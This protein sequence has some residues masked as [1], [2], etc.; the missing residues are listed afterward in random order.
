MTIVTYFTIVLIILTGIG[1]SQL[2]SIKFSET[3][4]IEQ[5]KTVYG[6]PYHKSSTSYASAKQLAPDVGILGVTPYEGATLPL[7][8]VTIDVLVYNW[9]DTDTASF[10]VNCTVQ[11]KTSWAYEPVTGNTTVTLN[12]TEYENVSFNWLPSN[13]GIYSINL[14]TNLSGDPNPNNN[15][16]TF[17]VTIANITDVELWIQFPLPGTYDLSPK[18]VTAELINVGNVN[19]TTD[20]NVHLEIINA[21]SYSIDHVDDQVQVASTISIPGNSTTIS[22]TSWTPSAPGTYWIN[23]TA[24]LPSDQNPNNDYDNITVTIVAAPAIHDVGVT[25][26][27]D[28]GSVCTE[29]VYLVNATITN[30]GTEL[31]GNIP[32]YCTIFNLNTGLTVYEQQAY[33]LNLAPGSSDTL[34]FPA[35]WNAVPGDYVINATTMLPTDV[36]N[37][38][39]FSVA[40]ITIIPG[41]VM[42][43]VHVIAPP[44]LYGKP[45]TTVVYE[46]RIV[47][48]GP[49][50]DSFNWTARSGHN[51]IKSPN[52]PDGTMTGTTGVLVP[53]EEEAVVIE[54][55]VPSDAGA[56]VTDRLNLTATSVA[57]PAVS[58]SNYT[59]TSTDEIYEVVVEVP[60]GQIQNGNPGD[61]LVYEF[62]VINEG[63][64]GDK[65][66]LSAIATYAERGWIATITSSNPTPYVEPGSSTLVTVML[67]IPELNRDTMI[68]DHTYAGATEQLTLRAECTNGYT[69]SAT[70]TTTVN[71]IYKAELRATPESIEVNYAGVTRE[72]RFTITVRN[73]CN[74]KDEVGGQ[75][76]IDLTNSTP[77]FIRGGLGDA[78]DVEASRY[79]ASLSDA[80]LTLP[81]GAAD[82]V[83]LT[84]TVP[85]KPLNGSCMVAVTG[86]PRGLSGDPTADR[87]PGTVAVYVY[88]R[89]I[90]GVEVKEPIPAIQR[91]APLQTLTYRFTIKNTGNGLDNFNLKSESEHDW[92]TAIVETTPIG[93]LW[94]DEEF[95]VRV[96]VTI[97]AG[98]SIG[99]TDILY[100][101]AWS[102]FNTSV[103]SKNFATT[104]VI[105]GYAVDLEPEENAS[106][107]KPRGSVNYTINVTNAGNGWDTIKLTLSYDVFIEGWSVQLSA[108]DFELEG[109]KRAFA[110]LTVRAS[111]DA[112]ADYKFKVT[113]TGRSAGNP[114]K[115]DI[116]NVTTAVSQIANVEIYPVPPAVRSGR[117]G[118]TLTY[119]LNVT[120]T[121]NGNDTFTLAAI[122]EHGNWSVRLQVD[123]VDLIP[124]ET[125]NIELKVSIPALSPIPTLQSLLANWTFAG[126]LNN[127]T[128]NATSEF[129]TTVRGTATVTAIVEQLYRV[130]LTCVD[131]FHE[132]LPDMETRY[133]IT[134]ENRG[135]GDDKLNLTLSGTR[136]LDWGR[137]EATGTQTMEL[138]LG[139][140]ATNKTGLIVFPANHTLPYWHEKGTVTVIATS[141][142]GI[143]SHSVTTITR[144]V[145]IYCEERRLNVDIGH[146]VT[147]KF[148]VMN[149]PKQH[150]PHLY[151]RI[152]LEHDLPQES[153]WNATF[154]L[155]ITSA[156]WVY[157]SQPVT[158][159]VR[160]PLDPAIIDECLFIKV[161]GRSNN[162]RTKYD[163][164]ETETTVVSIDFRLTAKDIKFENTI[165]GMEA[166][167]HI[168]VHAVGTKTVNNVVIHVYMD[169]TLIHTHIVD[170]VNG[171][172][173]I[174]ID[175][176]Y[177]LPQLKWYIKQEDHEFK[178]IVDPGNNIFESARYTAL[179]TTEQ[180]N[181]VTTTLTIHD[182]CLPPLISGTLIIIIIVGM[183]GLIF[184]I[185]RHPVLYICSGVML[186][187]L[188]ALLFTLP[189]YTLR[190][191]TELTNWIGIGI[192]ITFIAI[193]FPL[194]AI[195]SSRSANEYIRAKLEFD[196]TTTMRSSSY[197]Q[198]Q[199]GTEAAQTGLTTATSNNPAVLQQTVKPP[200]VAKPYVIAICTGAIMFIV[201]LIMIA[202]STVVTQNN[203]SEIYRMLL[204]YDLLAVLPPPMVIY[205]SIFVAIGVCAV[206]ITIKLQTYVY[207]HVKSA[208]SI[209]VHLRPREIVIPLPEEAA[210]MPQETIPQV[211]PT[212]P[213]ATIPGSELQS[214]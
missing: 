140:T 74:D 185:S 99:F 39:N 194:L 92:S 88:V 108:K 169:N 141:A 200:S 160:A 106:V 41:V 81:G 31:E 196:A 127:I 56:H 152:L 143:T 109:G 134:L 2:L 115:F 68:E 137:F 22:F 11:N 209:L 73:V 117:P 76:I 50:A 211:P 90:A 48:V 177:E 1:I 36:D 7:A 38:N 97:P 42:A 12:P 126:W 40:A 82:N 139:V 28:H 89:Q 72:V 105:Q 63:N 163:E 18:T 135:N 47:N 5:T 34:T 14:T 61:T 104:L 64:I 195:L 100:L 83:Y 178:V 19:I 15:N 9:N 33:V 45:G 27:W 95:E 107:V 30:F 156:L 98:T 121:G 21:T 46:F 103:T 91:G 167:I 114:A 142:D 79:I 184:V 129:N 153:L 149:V 172:S 203:L 93:P 186:G 204:T 16:Y 35:P 23:V 124:G 10:W 52:Q 25:A 205:T 87:I 193:L 192:I 166:H 44:D 168:V 179:A 57:N 188:G 197:P 138:E 116:V 132:I 67:K 101:Q 147:Y 174:E 146:A 208:E 66:N 214:R 125:A 122:A 154:N 183:I 171:T 159:T 136:G 6:A 206:F 17:N 155:E 207:E 102:L 213:A 164:V 191:D 70:I 69:D 198:G 151:D 128:V 84:V 199:R 110:I 71:L 8:P 201:Y 51:W 144:I 77:V 131:N 62:T 212:P 112:I 133:T 175:L 4:P 85:P 202:I 94:A 182:L 60:P 161:V 162:D 65:F 158:M 49:S 13:F 58:D 111:E 189:W 118:E 53:Y 113:I 29:G 24:Q 187:T 78:D 119:M 173:R 54:I 80:N 75:D 86:T 43:G 120:N 148:I 59:I 190:L 26:V 145:L 210:G 170:I 37:T 165:E 55:E 157:Q 20:F 130:S 176:R 150:E 96:K 181:N 3:A 32:V 180:N 123:S